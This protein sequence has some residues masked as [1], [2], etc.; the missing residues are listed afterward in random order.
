MINKVNTNF[1]NKKVNTHKIK[2]RSTKKIGFTL[3]EGSQDTHPT[4]NP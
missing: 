1:V 3:D 2:E 4:V